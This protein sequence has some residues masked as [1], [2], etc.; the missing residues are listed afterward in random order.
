MIR[1]VRP[2]VVEGSSAIASLAEKLMCSIVLA[3][4]GWLLLAP[5]SPASCCP[6]CP[7]ATP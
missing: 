4:L 7:R 1:E 2:S 5:C 6:S 3:P